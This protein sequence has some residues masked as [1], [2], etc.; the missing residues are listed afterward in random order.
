MTVVRS[1]TNDV[2][3]PV[4]IDGSAQSDDGDVIGE[5]RLA[6]ETEVAMLQQKRN[7]QRTDKTQLI[8]CGKER[9]SDGET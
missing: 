2:N 6:I 1:E 4:Q 9:S 7:Y 8:L 5:A 3:K